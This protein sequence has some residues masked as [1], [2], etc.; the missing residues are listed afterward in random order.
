VL[1][2]EFFPDFDGAGDLAQKQKNSK[3]A[4][5]TRVLPVFLFSLEQPGDPIL[6][7]QLSAFAASKDAVLVIQSGFD[8]VPIPFF[9]GGKQLL[10]SL[11]DPTAAIL[12]GVGSALGGLVP[13]Q[14]AFSQ[15]QGKT[16]TSM[17][18]AHGGTPFG[19]FGNSSSYSQIAIDQVLGNSFASRMDA[20][21]DR[22]NH[23]LLQM[24]EFA[25]TYLFDPLGESVET[26]KRM[27]WLERLKKRSELE[28][29]GAMPLSYATVRDLHDE[30]LAL[31]DV[32]SQ[33]AEAMYRLE[34]VHSHTLSDEIF[35]KASAFHSHA[36]NSLSHANLLLDCCSVTHQ[37]IPRTRWTFLARAFLVGLIACCVVALV[38][39]LNPRKQARRKPVVH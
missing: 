26:S 12:A 39:F 11:R 8:S 5:G 10:L 36:I 33:G 29:G 3:W 20:S 2:S 25:G 23:A 17:L 24:D 37:T 4:L 31:E 9:S 15:L 38:A 13:P 35:A 1:S 32:F 27:G 19:P 18:W 28:D 30:V 6:F 34:S 14:T 16:V 7:D 21:I 22:V